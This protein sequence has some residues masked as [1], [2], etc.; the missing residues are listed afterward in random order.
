[1]SRIFSPEVFSPA[2]FCLRTDI[3]AGAAFVLLCSAAGRCGRV[4]GRFDVQR[5]LPWKSAKCFVILRDPVCMPGCCLGATTARDSLELATCRSHMSRQ[6]L[7]SGD[8]LNECLGLLHAVLPRLILGRACPSAFVMQVGSDL[9]SIWFGK[10]TLLACFALSDGFMT[11]GPSGFKRSQSLE[12]P[13][14]RQLLVVTLIHWPWILR[15]SDLS[16]MTATLFNSDSSEMQ[17]FRRAYSWGGEGGP[18]TG[19][20]PLFKHCLANTQSSLLTWLVWWAV[21]VSLCQTP[22]KLMRPFS[23]ALIHLCWI[24]CA[25]C[26]SNDFHG[27]GLQVPFAPALSLVGTAG[28]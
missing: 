27:F 23:P 8:G 13:M 19:Q 24:S 17:N 1:M 15:G 2:S 10:E 26:A 11:L 4:L 3:S 14:A 5:K 22:L 20:G 25:G 18:M 9:G 21:K 16:K 12:M 28:I 7:S 6:E